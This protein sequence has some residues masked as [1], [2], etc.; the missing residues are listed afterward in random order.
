MRSDLVLSAAFGLALVGVSLA[1]APVRAMGGG[2]GGGGQMPSVSAPE[3]NAVE[4]YQRGTAAF[5]SG[6]YKDA[7]RDFEHVTEVQPKVAISWYMLGMARAAAGDVKGAA[8]AYERSVKIDPD[9]IDARREY[10]VSLARLKQK[11]K[12]AAQLEVLKA[13]AATCND[14][15]PQAADLKAAVTA[16]EAAMSAAGGTASLAS[17]A[18]LMFASAG[19]G[20]SAYVRAVSLINERR[21]PEALI[22]LQQAQQAFGPHPDI[23]TYQGYVWRKLGDLERAESLYRAAL[24]ISPTHRG[25]S[26]YYGELKVI[27]GDLAGARAMLAK[28]DTQCAFGC[29]EAEALRRWIDH[30]GDPAS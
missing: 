20:D 9:P 26:E 1:V 27:R 21:Y 17:P 16:V 5:Q 23:I 4:E 14:A 7:A 12:A 11:D 18:G 3:Y 15:C 24:A 8:H 22:A 10:A 29:A 30:G 13:R 6:K 25:A 19:E 2:G 28:L